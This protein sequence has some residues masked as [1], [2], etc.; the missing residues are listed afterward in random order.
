MVFRCQNTCY[1]VKVSLKMGT[2][3]VI[4]KVQMIRNCKNWFLPSKR[5]V[6]NEVI[7]KFSRGCSMHT[8]N[9]TACQLTLV[10]LPNNPL[11]CAATLVLLQVVRSSRH[12]FLLN[13][14][15]SSDVVPQSHVEPGEIPKIQRRK[16]QTFCR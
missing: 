9:C 10:V 4:Y 11:A 16:C 8:L 12:F 5:S 2:F 1:F 3:E 7:S 13:H 14:P 6:F 15:S